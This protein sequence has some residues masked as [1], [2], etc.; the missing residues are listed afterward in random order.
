M[1]TM[2]NFA[3]NVDE[4]FTSLENRI[5][6]LE[7]SHDRLLNTIDKFIGRIDNY[8]TEQVARDHEVARLK[9]WVEEIAKQT[10]VKLSA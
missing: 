7:A 8:E 1:E 10:G 4:R 3:D 6:K 9:R 5:D 2:S